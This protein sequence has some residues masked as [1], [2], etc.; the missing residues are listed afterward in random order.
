MNRI[1]LRLVFPLLL[2]LAATRLFAQEL[3]PAQQEVW[4]LEETYWSDVKASNAD[5]YASLWHQAFLGWPRDRDRPIGKKELTEGAQKKM[6]EGHVVSYEFLSKAVTAV[7]NVG[8]TQY[9]VKV[10]RTVK[11]GATETYTSRVTHTWMR[12][13]KIWEILGGMSSPYESSGHTW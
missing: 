1:P 11:D 9:S 10:T 12:R 8:V 7:G 5:H 4:Q 3:T 13:G 6:T 2:T